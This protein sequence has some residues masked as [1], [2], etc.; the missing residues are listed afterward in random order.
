VLAQYEFDPRSRK[1]NPTS[2]KLGVDCDGDGVIDME[3]FS[4]EAAEAQNEAV[5]FRIG[6]IYISTKRAD[7]E[8]N[9][10]VMKDHK[11]SDYKRIEIRIGGDVP[12]FEFTDFNGKKRR[13]SEFRGK[14]LL[15]DFWGM[16][17]PP[18]G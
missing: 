9:Q 14:H 5:V 18:W 1:V 6:S 4:P 11:A 2:G 7:V 15:I 10:I 13:L 12:D 3:P 17:C 16:W 8:K